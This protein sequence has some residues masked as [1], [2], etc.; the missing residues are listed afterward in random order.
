MKTAPITQIIPT[1]QGEGPN[2]GCT[3]L[4]IRVG[5]CNLCCPFCDTSWST[6]MATTT[7]DFM[8]SESTMIEFIDMLNSNYFDKYQINN[9]MIT[10]G[11]P[12]LYADILN[13]L[14]RELGSKCNQYNIE[15]ETN[16]T[17]INHSSLLEMFGDDLEDKMNITLNISPK[18]SKTCYKKKTTDQNV[19]EQYIKIF[20]DI[21]MVEFEY[22]RRFNRIYKFVY[23]V[24][25][26]NTIID[27]VVSGN[28]A[29]KDVFLMPLTP[30][31]KAFRSESIF[32]DKFKES[33]KNT[34]SA[35]LKY[36][37]RYSPREH[38]FV[39]GDSRNEILE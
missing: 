8:L 11:E 1:I 9:I 5:G 21:R 19:K 14:M 36:G 26:E 17:L 39:F 15:I 33:C 13:L 28:L 25:D 2:V 3:S 31:P 12:F 16:G 32:L 23:S 10:G 6:S 29:N 37:Y 22:T 4:I 7:N 30:N 34:I 24:D 18:L 35:C 27:I 38:V 20:E